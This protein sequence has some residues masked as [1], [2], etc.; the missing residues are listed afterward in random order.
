MIEVR[1][2]WMEIEWLTACRHGS[3]IRIPRPVFE[4]LTSVGFIE[5]VKDPNITPLGRSWLRVHVE[6]A[7]S[8][9]RG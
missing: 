8:S 2:S 4:R 9:R 5:G 1:L 3:A 6:P 7:T